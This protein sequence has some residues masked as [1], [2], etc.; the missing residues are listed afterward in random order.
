MMMISLDII[1]SS[2]YSYHVFMI[3]TQKL[4]IIQATHV[5]SER[6]STWA[7]YFPY[8]IF[9]DDNNIKRQINIGNVT[10]YT[11]K[12]LKSFVDIRNL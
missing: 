2:Y 8:L 11:K 1:V 10:R 12:I 9:T 7:P 4:F 3:A 6:Q 5:L